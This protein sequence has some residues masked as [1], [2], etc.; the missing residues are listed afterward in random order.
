MKREFTR[1]ELYD[2]VWS[3]PMRAIATSLGLSDVALA[4]HCKKADIPVPSRG[5]WARKQASKP[6]IQVEL[7]PRSPGASDRVGG[8][9]G[10]GHYWGSDWPEHFRQADIPAVPVFDEEIAAVADRARK[11]VGKVRCPR[12][13]ETPH[14]LVAK[15]LGHDEERRTSHAKWG[16]RYDTPKYDAGPE[17]RRLLIL[18]AL[19]MAATRLGCRPSMSTSKYV[20]DGNDREIGITIGQ[21]HI[22]FTIEPVK[23]KTAEKKER[24]RLAFGMARDREHATKFWEDTAAHPLEERLAEVL[25]EMLVSAEAAYRERLVRQREWIIERKAEAEAEIKR[26]QEEAARKARELEEKL[27]RERIARLLSQAKALDRANQIRSYV[28]AAL[29]RAAE[30]RVLSE[31]MEEWA[32]WARQ[33]ADS[34]DP[35]KNGTFTAVV[36]G[37]RGAKSIL[38]AD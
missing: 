9:D 32:A 20:Q 36:Q 38:D 30:L 7:P 2:L 16:S 33:Q 6:T 28:D 3:Q 4:K 14:P 18:N 24:L 13:F 26:R 11:L 5:Y 12:N 29:C 34:I 19:F 15:L 10:G 35:V 8:I 37:L 23:A 1:R 17:R 31:A 21:T 25:V 22:C 27:A